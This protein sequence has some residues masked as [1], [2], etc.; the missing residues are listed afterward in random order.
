[1]PH[2]DRNFFVYWMIALFSWEWIWVNTPRRC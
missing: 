2:T 1:M